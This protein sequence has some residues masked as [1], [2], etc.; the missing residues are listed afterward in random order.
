MC[1]HRFNWMGMSRRTGDMSAGGG[2]GRT[3]IT[4]PCSS[5]LDGRRKTETPLH[6]QSKPSVDNSH[7]WHYWGASGAAGG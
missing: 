5:K 1:G 7:V 6:Y 3:P 2:V 4:A